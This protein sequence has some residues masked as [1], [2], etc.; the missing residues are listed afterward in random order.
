[1][2]TEHQF[3]FTPSAYI[4]QEKKRNMAA[5][6]ACRLL[7]LTFIQRVEDQATG[8]VDKPKPKGCTKN[9]KHVNTSKLPK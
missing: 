9:T 6:R 2:C 3:S 5:V 7:K 8:F 1:V 4:K